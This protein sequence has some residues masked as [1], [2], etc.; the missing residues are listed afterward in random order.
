MDQSTPLPY[1][2]SVK[3]PHF[4][5]PPE[6]KSDLLMYRDQFIEEI[7]E[8]DRLFH[9]DERT[10]RFVT[11]YG[12]AGAGKSFVALQYGRQKQLTK[13]LDAVLWIESGTPG[14]RSGLEGE[15]P[16][17]ARLLH[18]PGRKRTLRSRT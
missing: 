1:H 14:S 8:I 9:A 4:F 16:P 3:L 12:A 13:E 18:L 7:K 5:L 11:L 15:F 17:I 6:Q 2:D 10:L